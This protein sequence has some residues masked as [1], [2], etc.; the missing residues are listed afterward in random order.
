MSET[1]PAFLAFATQAATA[2]VAAGM[3][4]T[5][6]RLVR[7]PTMADR[8]LALD[9]LTLLGVGLIAIVAVMTDR[10]LYLD[11]AIGLALVSFLATA[12]FARFIQQ[13]GPEPGAKAPD[14]PDE[15]PGKEA[16]DA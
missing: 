11:V 15:A 1:G 10:P 6:I 2:L 8:V 12:A 13:R 5:F 14:L 16:D 9:L 7:G 4:M 3:V